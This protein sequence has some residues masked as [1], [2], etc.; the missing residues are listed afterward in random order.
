M[1]KK[2]FVGLL[3]MFLGLVGFTGIKAAASN[4]NAWVKVEEKSSSEV[5]AQIVTDGKSSYGELVVKYDATGL[6]VSEEDIVVNED[7]E[8][9]AV[10][11]TE[12]G[13]VVIVYLSEEPVEKGTLATV[14]FE[15]E[16]SSY[17]AGKFELTGESYTASGETLVVA[18]EPGDYEEKIPQ[19]DNKDDSNKGDSNTGDSNTGD[20][21]SGDSGGGNSGSGNSG[22]NNLGQGAADN[23]DSSSEKEPGERFDR[24][25]IVDPK[26]VEQVAS[27][28][29]N[30]GSG[31]STEKTQPTDTESKEDDKKQDT[32]ASGA[33]SEKS[34][35]QTASKTE[36]KETKDNTPLIILAVVA[37][38][39][40]GAVAM[41]VVVT[42]KKTK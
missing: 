36:V 42:R 4:T 32:Q 22:S 12:S 17:D 35:T 5:E 10:N 11:V 38:I 41:G 1:K 24:E 31:D 30:Q 25:D 2:V 27:N 29:S 15:V 14:S 8:L 37:V 39:V 3:T 34:D 33:S 7:I 13:E 23:G 18:K 6:S 26:D 20:S 40:V 9:Y 16:D 21:G 19:D 28:D